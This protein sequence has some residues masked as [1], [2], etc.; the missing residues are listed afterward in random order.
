MPQRWMT[1]GRKWK[2]CY[3]IKGA[4]M[5]PLKWP[6]WIAVVIAIEG[7]SSSF[8]V[9][10]VK[11]CIIVQSLAKKMHGSPCISTYAKQASII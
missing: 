11:T 4:G 5:T 3:Q 8:I 9:L 1:L 10:A 6:L 7:V 2:N